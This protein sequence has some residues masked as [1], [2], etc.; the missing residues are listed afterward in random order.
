MTG[1]MSGHVPVLLNEVLPLTVS[2]V[3]HGKWLTPVIMRPA[4]SRG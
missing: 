4:G 3:I 1:P 2:L